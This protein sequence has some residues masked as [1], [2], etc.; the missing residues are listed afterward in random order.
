MKFLQ[1]LR[2]KINAFR[3]NQDSKKR[4]RIIQKSIDPE[5]I[6]HLL[7]QIIISKEWY[8]SSYGGF[9]V[10]P[11][12]INK[13]S[14]IYSFG[15][16]KD[17]SFDLKLLK[18][19]N[20]NIFAFDPTPN[21][22]QWVSRQTL[23]KKIQFFPFGI[24]TFDGDTLFH[25]PINKKRISGS[26]LSISE[27]NSTTILVIMK[28]LTTIMSELNHKEIDLLK[29]DI[30]GAEYDVI[31]EILKSQIYPK[32]L[33]VEFHDRMVENKTKNSHNIVQLMEQHGYKVFANSVSF[34]EIS[35]IHLKKDVSLSLAKF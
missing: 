33:I 6:I 34:E 35:F 1:I 9:Y 22:I 12:I 16:G 15:V 3:L 20:C 7:P 28:T 5:S 11:E 27:E 30:E 26:L 18:N 32:Q 10:H 29:M 23:H 17:L 21:S 2:D 8:G 13:D 24:S 19:H 4:K 31:P 25:I 14:I